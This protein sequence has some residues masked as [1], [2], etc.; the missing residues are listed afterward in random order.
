MTFSEKLSKMDPELASAIESEQT[1]QEEHIELIASENY[2]S[3]EVMEIQGSVL[4]NKYAEGYPGRRYYGGCEHVDEA[5]VLAIERVKSLF[6]A[7]YANVQPHS[8]SQANMAVYMSLL[9][10]G[11]RILGMSL[12]DGG[13]LTHG[14]KVNFSGQLYQF[15]SYGLN[16]DTGRIDYDQVSELAQK[17]RPKMIVAGFSAYS[18][19]VDWTKFR[20]IADSINAYFMVDM[21]HVAGLIAGDC[22]PNPVPIADVTTSTTHKTLRGPRGGIILARENEEIQKAINKQVFPGTQG[23]PLMHVIAAKAHAFSEALK[24]EFKV[25]QQAVIQNA[26]AMASRFQ[27]HGYQVVSDGTDC[28]LF[29]LDL[30]DTDVT[31]ADGEKALGEANITLNKNSVP[32][33]QRS[34]M[35]TSGLRIGSPAITTRGFGVSEAEYVVDLIHEVLSDIHNESNIS[36]VKN[37][38]KDL[39]KGFPV[40]LQ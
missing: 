22:Y 1:R 3:S 40:Y 25:Y 29:L 2:T 21:A 15:L 35:I 5:E 18:R 9:D 36:S 4:T 23:G 20:E 14:A 38:A 32:N 34:P 6:N 8:G 13:H 19:L 26:K 31:G 16:P 10:H 30:S 39:C 7:D 33:D 24:P 17:H 11:D 28:H 27:K 12:S 37:K